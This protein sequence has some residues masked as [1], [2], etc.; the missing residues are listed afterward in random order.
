MA[1]LDDALIHQNYGTIDHVVETD[2]RWFDR[3]YFN[4]QALDGS[5]SLS[6]GTGV[7]P[8]QQVMDGF[9]IVATPGRPG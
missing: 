4:V 3:F 9:G 7:Y 8:N 2:A 5:M 1:R 6:Q